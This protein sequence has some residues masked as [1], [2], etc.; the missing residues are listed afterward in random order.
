MQGTRFATADDVRIDCFLLVVVLTSCASDEDSAAP[1]SG[2]A[3]AACPAGETCSADFGKVLLEGPYGRQ[4][5]PP[6]A[7]ATATAVGGVQEM[8]LRPTEGDVNRVYE[9]WHLELSDADFFVVDKTSAN[10]VIVEAL[11]AGMSVLDVRDGE[12][13]LIDR[14]ELWAAP[15][16]SVQLLTAG[17]SGS[18]PISLS[19]PFSLYPGSQ[20]YVS[21]RL[22]DATGQLLVDEGMVLDG[23]E[24]QAWD[25]VIVT[26]TATAAPPLTVT[27]SSGFSVTF[28]FPVAAPITVAPTAGSANDY[29][30][31]EA[32]DAAGLPVASAPWT[33][34]ASGGRSS[35]YNCI[36]LSGPPGDYPLDITVGTLVTHLTFHK[37]RS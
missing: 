24:R 8:I 9:G 34:L 11:G 3:A 4:I 10:G 21:A 31:F 37:T 1:D 5:E 7:F 15:V 33:I 25:S 18:S 28:A 20:P 12:G 14:V 6:S 32:L 27:S 16:A 13:K 26:A 30:C 22:L 29:P 2:V 23:G 17:V 35:P 19:S 36:P